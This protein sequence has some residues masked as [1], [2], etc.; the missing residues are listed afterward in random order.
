MRI[1][2]IESDGSGGLVHYAYQLCTALAEEGCEV[3]LVTAVD[4]ELDHFPHN[5]QVVK[6]L[7]LWERYEKEVETIADASKLRRGFR[8]IYTKVRRAFRAVRWV[9]AW[10]HLTFFLLRSKPDII[11]FSKMH[12]AFE[13]YFIHYLRKRGIF[14]SQICHEFEEREGQSYLESLLLGVRKDVYTNFSAIFLH[15]KENR[16]RF[17]KLYPSVPE[18]SLHIIEH[19]NSKW[20]LRFTPHELEIAKKRREYGLQE[21]QKVVLFFGLLAP[22]KGLDDLIEAFAIASKECDARLL[23][24]GYPTK[25]IDMTELKKNIARLNL[26]DKVL[27][28]LRYLRVEEIGLLMHL[29]TVVVYPYR[30]STQSGA[31][32]AAY[33]FGKPVIASMA[34]GLPEVVEDGKSGFLVPVQSPVE[35]AKRITELISNPSLAENMGNYARHLADTRFSWNTIAKKILAV[36][37]S[38]DEF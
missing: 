31:L 36:Y 16:D 11:Q 20:L 1:F 30:S 24:A 25:F 21:G 28:D 38:L 18:K 3:T 33:I 17:K 37:E 6:L 32:Q 8:G 15:A 4:Y 29:A 5:F 7:R 12:F 9:L 27:F 26:T 23:I 10:A 22:S 13:S 34:G 14:L 19:G 2:V 35:L